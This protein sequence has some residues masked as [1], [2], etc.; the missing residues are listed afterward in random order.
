M[1]VVNFL[2]YFGTRSGRGVFFKDL[3]ALPAT[4]PGT[5]TI[6]LF[7]LISV[8]RFHLY[9]GCFRDLKLKFASKSA[10]RPV[11]LGSLTPATLP[12]CLSSALLVSV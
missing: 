7:T 3:Y 9:E 4:G 1:V 8:A 6:N 10:K 11:A 2:Y 12:N 5:W